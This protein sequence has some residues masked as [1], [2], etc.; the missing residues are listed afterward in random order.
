MDESSGPASM[1]EPARMPPASHP[2]VTGLVPALDADAAARHR[3]ERELRDALDEA[4][5][6][7]PAYARFEADLAAY[8]RQ[9]MTALICTGYI[10]ARCK[11]AGYPLLALPIPLD[12]REDLVQET[13]EKALS[14]FKHNGLER[15]GWK[16]E[17]GRSLNAYFAHTLLGQFSNIWKKRVKDLQA[18]TAHNG[19][20]LNALPPGTWSPCAD[21]A[22]IYE[23]RDEVR[24][25]LAGIA[26]HR[27]RV[28]IMLTEFGYSQDEIAE[29]L[30]VSRRAVE[31]YL[32]RH[33]H[34]LAN[35][36]NRGVR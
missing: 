31:G 14:S 23:Q 24:R 28:A 13:V 3:A 29:I 32:R 19:P 30:D 11:E 33:R 22:D 9:L 7:G 2:A 12:D 26:N 4:G 21:P 20:L 8:G 17:L 36:G 6:T 16:P 25:G 35:G 1:A 15:D 10:F 18:R 34:G 27:T 5:F